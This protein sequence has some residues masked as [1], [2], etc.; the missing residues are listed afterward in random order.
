[1]EDDFILT[2]K[3]INEPADLTLSL[4][5]LNCLEN[6]FP[7]CMRYSVSVC[8]KASLRLWWLTM[9]SVFYQ[10]DLLSLDKRDI[11]FSLTYLASLEIL[12]PLPEFKILKCLARPREFVKMDPLAGLEGHLVVFFFLKINTKNGLK[13]LF[14]NK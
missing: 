14:V 5:F 4:G 2:D 11:K 10:K 9:A 7:H 8:S 13:W 1:M 12:W 6:P 3:H